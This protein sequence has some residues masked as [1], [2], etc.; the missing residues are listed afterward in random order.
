M[1]DD[2]QPWTLAR[3]YADLCSLR[4]VAQELDVD[5]FRVY[6]WTARRA[7]TNAP[8]PVR[9]LAGTDIYSMEEWKAWYE[10]WKRTRGWERFG[11]Q[12]K[13][14]SAPVEQPQPEE[15]DEAD[16]TDEADEFELLRMLLVALSDDDAE[17]GD[18][19]GGQ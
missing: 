16:A 14:F 4:E 8:F 9:K 1:D 19:E 15:Q 17:H 3:I 6:R 11:K 18:G 13:P 7:K 2:D 12:M 5:H 10:R